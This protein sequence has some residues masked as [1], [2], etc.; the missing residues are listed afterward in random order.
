MEELDPSPYYMS[1]I[2]IVIASLALLVTVLLYLRLR[3]GNRPTITN[4]DLLNEVKK[5]FRDLES[6]LQTGGATESVLKEVKAMR[7]DLESK[8]EKRDASG[9]VLD[10]VRKL[11]REFDSRFGTKFSNYV[12]EPDDAFAF[13]YAVS[14]SLE[15]FEHDLSAVEDTD[16]DIIREAEGYVAI[17]QLLLSWAQ[18]N[19]RDSIRAKA[20]E[21]L[22]AAKGTLEKA[23]AVA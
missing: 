12:F 7:Q 10:E 2:A 13:F 18:A 6:K 23:R 20:E 17:V 5:H 14:S 3:R 21:F 16:I 19:G 1:V 8:Y 15:R 11:R 22:K 4:G 9:G